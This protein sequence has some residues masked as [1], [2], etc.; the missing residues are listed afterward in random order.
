M[1]MDFDLKA[2]M[3]VLRKRLW[4]IVLVVA[5]SCTAAGIVSYFF[6]KPVY[7]ASSK[8]IINS[9]PDQA[10]VVKLDLNSVNTNISL[11]TT[12]KEIIKTPA[13][14]DIVAK[15]HPE[16]GMTSEQLIS[17]IKLSS[18][19]ETQ[20]LTISIQDSSYEKAAHIV[21]AVFQ[22]FQ[23]QIPKIMKVDNVILLNQADPAKQPR[24]IKP[25][26][27]LNIALGFLASLMLSVGLVFLLEYMDDTV[28]TEEDVQR[29]L[30]L[31]TLALI[32][33]I[34]EQDLETNKGS[35]SS[36]RKVGELSNVQV[37]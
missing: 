37:R 26:P 19:N 29:Y 36:E 33:Q 12:Y 15:D 5:V 14:M 13:I 6:M 1:T 8:L 30:G 17:K 25:D 21:N 2:V 20:V 22:V 28:K 24:P 3:S 11:V 23:S 31:P 4:L 9:S 7:E 32:T 34:D 35:L 10:G 18:V 27:L 16:F